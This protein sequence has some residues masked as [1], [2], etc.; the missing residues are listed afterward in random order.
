MSNTFSNCNSFDELYKKQIEWLTGQSTSTGYETKR[1]LEQLEGD[2]DFI[3]LLTC[4]S[5][6]SKMITITSQPSSCY[7][8]DNGKRPKL[9]NKSDKKLYRMLKKPN[10]TILTR[11]YIQGAVS[12]DMFFKILK[13]TQTDLI[14]FGVLPFLTYDSIKLHKK[15][16]LKYNIVQPTQHV[17]FI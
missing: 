10:I 6:H 4:A 14:I 8:K 15:D 17:V 12:I 11:P 13:H 1:T 2:F 3:N 7:T 5:I 9:I 16:K